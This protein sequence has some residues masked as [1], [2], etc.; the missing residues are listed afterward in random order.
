MNTVLFDLDGTLLP[1]DTLSFVKIYLHTLSKAFPEIPAELLQKGIMGG[2]KA[3]E[4]NPGGKSNRSVFA[5]SFAALGLEFYSRESRFLQYYN[6]DFR[7]CLA[8]CQ[9]TPLARE[10]TDLLLEKGYTVAIATNPIFPRDATRNRLKWI[11]LDP[12]RFALVTTY[13]DID[14]AKP[15]PEYFREVCR[16]I[17]KR[18]EECV[19]IGNHVRED[20][21]AR[22]AGIP[23]MLVT[24]CLINHDQTPLDDFWVG[25]LEDVRNWAAELPVLTEKEES[26]K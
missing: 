6:T 9:P 10:I 20:G 17:G 14:R 13:E 3:M 25:T 4:N 7:D 5:E 24:D 22:D 26:G 16:R 8:A 12:D 15:D 21:G 11:G 19:H 23:V 2:L 1:M 18:P